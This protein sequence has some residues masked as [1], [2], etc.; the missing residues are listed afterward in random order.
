MPWLYYHEAAESVL[1]DES[2]P[3]SYQFPDDTMLLLAAVF[4]P[5][6]SFRGYR[7]TTGGLLQLCKNSDTFM[8]AAYVFGTTFDHT[9]SVLI[10]SLLRVT[11]MVKMEL[12]L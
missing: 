12:L 6:G 4:R 10:L 7:R 1:A 3:N 9:V 5:D 2:I 8:D 11:M